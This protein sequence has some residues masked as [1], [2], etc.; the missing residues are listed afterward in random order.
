VDQH[1]LADCESLAN[2]D[3]IPLPTSLILAYWICNRR[4]PWEVL[5]PFPAVFATIVE[6]D[7]AGLLDWDVPSAW[8]GIGVALA[9]YHAA[10]AVC[11]ATSEVVG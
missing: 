5:R 2:S 11:R 7:D 10:V 1:V 4:W 8:E 6:L 3:V 9:T